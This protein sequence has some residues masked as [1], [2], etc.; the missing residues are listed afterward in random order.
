MKIWR[1]TRFIDKKKRCCE[2]T[3]GRSKNPMNHTAG[4]SCLR[5]TKAGQDVVIFQQKI[6]NTMHTHM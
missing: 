2:L 5:D 1:D 3:Y 4:F 6:E